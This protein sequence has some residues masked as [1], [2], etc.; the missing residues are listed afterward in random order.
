MTAR[1]L[2]SLGANLGNSRQLIQLA[3]EMIRD[4]FGSNRVVFSRM[5]RSPA[6]GGPA[7]QDD[8]YNAVAVIESSLDKFGLWQALHSIEQTLGRHRRLRWEAR[9]ID[10]DILLHDQ[11]RLWT[12]TLKIPHPRMSIRT[13]V[14]EPAAEIAAD[15][16]EPVTGTTIKQ[17]RDELRILPPLA[18]SYGR[19]AGGEGLLSAV[20][21]PDRAS[22][23]I[24]L[25]TE[26]DE[27]YSAF[28]QAQPDFIQVH[29]VPLLDRR[30]NHQYVDAYR[31]TLTEQLNEAMQRSP[32]LIAFAGSSPDPTSIHWEDY[33]R[34][35]AEVFRLNR[36]SQ[37]S[38]VDIADSAFDRTPKYLLSAEDTQWAIH[39]LQAALTAMTCLASPCGEFFDIA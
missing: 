14:L 34:V 21:T 39:E 12:P 31:S 6:V 17:L 36:P 15:W 33:C 16:I 25:L 5:Y 35:W 20:S 23:R 1:S 26:S 22:P 29:R 11:E 32:R 7:G 19:G 3:G 9:R 13:F 4:R 28:F 18:H 24:L 27:A 37:Q 2:I 8:F 38:E 30:S 10:L